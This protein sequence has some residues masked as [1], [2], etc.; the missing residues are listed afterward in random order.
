MNIS[1]NFYNLNPSQNSNFPTNRKNNPSFSAV[2]YKITSDE[3]NSINVLKNFAE[4]WINILFNN[5]NFKEITEEYDGIISFKNK[6]VKKTGLDKM[7]SENPDKYVAEASIQI[8]NKNKYIKTEIIDLDK[9]LLDLDEKHAEKYS[10]IF[11]RIIK[12]LYNK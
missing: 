3:I 1:N 5:K 2:K 7:L 8:K 6:W 10:K 11:G 9:P 12:E 4:N